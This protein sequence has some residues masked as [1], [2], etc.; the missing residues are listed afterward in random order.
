MDLTTILVLCVIMYFGFLLVKVHLEQK[1]QLRQ[2]A[3]KHI[4][5]CIHEVKVEVDRGIEYWFDSE[6]NQFLAQGSSREEIYKVIK[7]R[8]NGH[9]FL[10]KDGILSGPDYTLQKFRDAESLSKAMK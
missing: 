10:C 5:S 4:A 1:I 9:V 8:F 2:R 6:T 7:S 3:I